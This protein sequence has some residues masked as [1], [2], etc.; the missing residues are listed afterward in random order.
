[1]SNRP[2]ERPPAAGCGYKTVTFDPEAVRQFEFA[3]WEQA[4][5]AYD[6]TFARATAGFVEVL[7]D[8]AEVSAEMFLLDLCC[9]TGLVG[10]AGAQRGALST[11][12]DFSPGML[13][14][15]RANHPELRFDK[16]DAEALPYRDH[17]FDSVVSNFGLHHV[18]KPERAVAE[19]MRVLRPGGRFGFTTWAVPAENIAWQLLFD[20]VTAE[21]D[22]EAAKAP[23][24]GGGLGQ[25]AAVLRLLANARFEQPAARMVRR[26]WRL[27]SAAELLESLS[28]GTVRTAALIASQRP[29]A[30]P[31]ITAHI[32]EAM[33]AYRKD[34][35]F[36]VPIVAI[37][38]RGTKP[39]Q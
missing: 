23:P 19:A 4:A 11:G 39:P 12:L 14:R 26:E 6:A 25:V 9:G 27:A 31:A 3:G 2:N 1:M 38:V 33:R 29:D 30:I 22:L 21:G 5:A 8:A 32:A 15:A 36:A 13:A 24:S 20:A 28:Q 7:L 18:P 34:N 10:A 35:T 16:G 37:L 17:S